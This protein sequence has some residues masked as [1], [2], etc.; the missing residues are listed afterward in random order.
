MNK[1]INVPNGGVGWP[2]SRGSPGAPVSAHGGAVAPCGSRGRGCRG[3][4]AGTTAGPLPSAPPLP[5]PSGR[6]PTPGRQESAFPSEPCLSAGAAGSCA[7]GT[8]TKHWWPQTATQIPASLLLSRARG[9]KAE[10]RAALIR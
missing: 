8:G 5:A 4:S 6:S 3:G 9:Q 10:S 7:Q 2:L 1:G